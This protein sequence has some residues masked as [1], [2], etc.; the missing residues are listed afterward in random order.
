MKLASSVLLAVSSVTII[1]AAAYFGKNYLSHSSTPKPQTTQ[2]A[3]NDTTGPCGALSATVNG[4]KIPS[5]LLNMI[6]SNAKEQQQTPEITPEVC[7]EIM[8]KLV[9]S[10]LLAD[11]ANKQKVDG[12]LLVQQRLLLAQQ[13]VLGKAVQ[14]D[15]TKTVVVSDADLQKEFDSLGLGE[16]F[17]FRH[18]LVKTEAEA[19]DLLAKLKQG[20]DFAK[21]A[22]EFSQDTGSKDNGGGMDFVG[23]TQL[24]KPFGDA[25]KQLKKGE[26]TSQPVKTEF[27][28]HIIQLEDTRPSSTTLEQVRG[29]LTN[30]IKEDK[31]KTLVEKLKTEAKIEIK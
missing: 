14:D 26:M 25:L 8:D 4:T 6:V 3:A 15:F 12:Q 9:M 13:S 29:P 19:Q 31:F 30:K 24:S 18:I 1:G 28:F 16:E 27:G 2:T 5:G 17:K 20:G 21:L 11:Y 7:K 23:R 10:Q 22:K